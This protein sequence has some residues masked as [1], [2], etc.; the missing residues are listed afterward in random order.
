M[1]MTFKVGDQVVWKSQA[2]G[3]GPR[4]K[5][6]RIVAV[7]N[8]MEQPNDALSRV[9]ERGRLRFP[10]LVRREVSYVV[11]VQGRGLYW[12]RVDY[13]RMEEPAEEPRARVLS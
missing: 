5:R 2:G 12:P 13:L 9:R 11:R 3:S 8:Y 4:E 7:V 10:G 1:E 6:G